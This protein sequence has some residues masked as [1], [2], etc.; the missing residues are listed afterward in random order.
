VRRPHVC[1]HCSA[2]CVLVAYPRFSARA[3][4]VWHGRRTASRWESGSSLEGIN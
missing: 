1:W 2:S 3:G 4:P